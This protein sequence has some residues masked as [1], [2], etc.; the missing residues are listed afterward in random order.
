MRLAKKVMAVALAAAMASFDA[1]RLRRWWRRRKRLQQRFFQLE[2]Q[3]FQ[4]LS[5][6]LS[7]SSARVIFQLFEQ[8]LQPSGTTT[9]AKN[10]AEQQHKLN[11]KVAF[12]SREQLSEE[13]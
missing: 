11:V 8:Q 13:Q 4:Q 12:T 3:L 1:H 10:I 7:S 9:D 6:K 5:S 2:Q